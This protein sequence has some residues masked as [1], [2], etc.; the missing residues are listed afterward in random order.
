MDG[1]LNDDVLLFL[2]YFKV[3]KVVIL[4]VGVGEY[5]VIDELQQ[6]VIILFYV[7]EVLVYDDFLNIVN[8][9]KEFFCNGKI[10]V[11]E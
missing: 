8:K 4:V 2:V 9:I 3:M 6:I 5:Y 7:F 10:E 1:M 11:I